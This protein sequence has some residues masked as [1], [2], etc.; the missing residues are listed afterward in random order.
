MSLVATLE[1]L[2]K[3]REYV[4][5]GERVR[6]ARSLDLL[7]IRQRGAWQTLAAFGST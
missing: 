1:L 4:A 6:S 3:A 2:V 7:H 5:E